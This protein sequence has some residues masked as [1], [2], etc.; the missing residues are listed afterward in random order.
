MV[1]QSR[2]SPTLGTLVQPEPSWGDGSRLSNRSVEA[3]ETIIPYYTVVCSRAVSSS[4]RSSDDRNVPGRLLSTTSFAA[5]WHI[6]KHDSCT[7]MHTVQQP[8]QPPICKSAG[9]SGPNLRGPPICPDPHR[10]AGTGVYTEVAFSPKTTRFRRIPPNTPPSGP[11]FFA[12]CDSSV[13]LGGR[14]LLPGSSHITFL[15]AVV[16]RGDTRTSHATGQKPGKNEV[17]AGEW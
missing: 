4:C 11:F 16:S 1:S 3:R 6:P 7:L 9:P 2:A 15:E 10:P 13:C 17:R 14:F 8:P 12:P 5:R